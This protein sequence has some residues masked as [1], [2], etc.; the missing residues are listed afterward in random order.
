MQGHP[1]NDFNGDGKSDVLWRTDNGVLFNWVATGLGAFTSNAANFATVVSSEWRVAGTGDFNGDGFTD[2]FWR[3]DVTGH[4]V[5]WLGNSTG[6]FTINATN[7]DSSL[8]SDAHIVG[9]GD[10][11]GDGRDDILIQKD[12]GYTFTWLGTQSGGFSSGD[13]F[14]MSVNRD[15]IIGTGDFNGDGRDDILAR[16]AGDSGVLFEWTGNASGGFNYYNLHST[17]AVVMPPD[18]SLS[19]TGD[20]N[21][22]GHEDILWRRNDGLLFNWL[23]ANDG[24]TDNSA[25]LSIMVSTEWRVISIGDF[26]GDGRDDILWRQDGTGRLLDWLATPNGGFVTN[27][28]NFESSVPPYVHHQDPFL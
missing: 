17:H 6:G 1:H 7:F 25:N 14:W 28:G 13:F 23:G 5:D 16:M 18:V 15:R 12:D 27:A 4:V 10:Y 11:N 20:F 22:D 9:T 2:L 24:F 21:G 8:P 3:Q 19:G 26:N